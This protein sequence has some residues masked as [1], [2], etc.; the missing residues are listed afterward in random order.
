MKAQRRDTRARERNYGT[1][2]RDEM[3]VG[4]A[5]GKHGKAK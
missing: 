3:W 4:Y 5:Q 1:A 2:E